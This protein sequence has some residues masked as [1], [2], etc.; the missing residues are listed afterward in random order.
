[1]TPSCHGYILSLISLFYLPF[2]NIEGKVLKLI[3]D[4]M[5]Y[6]KHKMLNRQLA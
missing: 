6:R 5:W 4:K 3:K 1:M 2:N